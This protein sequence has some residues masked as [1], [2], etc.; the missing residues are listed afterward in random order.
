MVSEI[1]KI[2]RSSDGGGNMN[3]EE[4]YEYTNT[5]TGGEEMP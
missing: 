4:L 1:E 3:L 5:N 2:S